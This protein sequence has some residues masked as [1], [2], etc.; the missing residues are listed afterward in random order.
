MAVPTLPKTSR[1]TV[2]ACFA[3]QV[4]AIYVVANHP[5]R[6]LWLSIAAFFAGGFVTDLISGLAHFGFDYLWPPD[7]PIFGPIALEFRQHHEDPTL[8]PSAVLSNITKG[9]Y[10]ALPLACITWALTLLSGPGKGAFLIAASL[11]ATSLWMLG[12]HQIHAYAHMGSRLPPQQF[13]AAVVEISQLATA[14][15]RRI[16]FRK[17]FDSL[18]IPKPVRL[19]QRCRLFLRPEIHWQHHESF[20]TDFSSVN[21]WSDPLTNSIF[22]RVA[23][24]KRK[25]DAARA[26]LLMS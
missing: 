25:K 4:C 26:A 2:A 6:G 12:F 13:K 9:A 23:R 11:L 21:G 3:A 19:L 15:Q 5:G 14:R 1:A 7:T 8:D 16:A 10:G 22:S 24:W 18:G 17:L 20:E